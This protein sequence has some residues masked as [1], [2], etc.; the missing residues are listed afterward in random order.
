MV[1]VLVTGV[2]AA[3]GRAAARSLLATGGQVRVWVDDDGPDPDEQA[4][5]WRARGCKVA[6]GTLDDE[7]RLESAME[8][9]HTVVH[10]AGGLLAPPDELLDGVAS[11]VSA[12][13]GAGV[14]RVVWSSALGAGDDAGSTWL[15]ACADAEALLADAPLESVVLRCALAY[16]ADDPLTQT[17][18]AGAGAARDASHAPLWAGDVG[19]AVR[20]ADADRAPAGELHVVVSLAGPDVVTLGGLSARLAERVTAAGVLPPW[21]VEVLAR[22]AVGPPDA[23]GRAGTRLAEGL[24]RLSQ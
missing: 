7:G 4:A 10:L 21:A 12:A 19:D 22:D 1:P 9:V 3:V 5:Q 17:I 16:G 2:E 11:V 23:L 15:Q 18:A 6:R 14:P 20:A 24:A 8:Q 13:V